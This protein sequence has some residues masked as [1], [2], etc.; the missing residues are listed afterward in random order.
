MECSVFYGDE[1]DDL[2]GSEP[3]IVRITPLSK[4]K[5]FLCWVVLLPFLFLKENRTR[6]ALWIFLPYYAWMG[7]AAGMGGLGSMGGTV[8]SLAA[9]LGGLLL[10]GQRLGKRPGGIVALAAIFG[11]AL[12]GAMV[13]WSGQAESLAVSAMGV[14][15]LALFIPVL[16]SLARLFC[17]R[18]YGGPKLALGLLAALLL[19]VIPL[20]ALVVGLIFMQFGEAMPGN[21]AMMLMGTTIPAFLCSLA[22]YAVLMSF[23]AVP[24]S[25]EFY[26]ARLCGLLK[27]KRDVSPAIAP[28][29][30]PL[31]H[32]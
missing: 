19:C 7:V 14:G 5:G 21:W 20:T 6:K 3:L 1:G 30:V 10:A 2:L 25:S 13:V 17:R 4:L 9:T 8:V 26:R 31:A 12:A 28:P 22:I 32:P 23:L 16:F 27:L 24:F 11:H 15:V 18:R 29:P